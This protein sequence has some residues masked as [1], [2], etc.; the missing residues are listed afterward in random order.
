V[1]CGAHLEIAAHGELLLLNVERPF[2]LPPV[3]PTEEVAKTIVSLV[4]RPQREV[5]VANAARVFNAMHTLVPAPFEAMMARQVEKTDFQQG[6]APAP[7]SCRGMLLLEDS[8]KENWRYLAVPLP[9]SLPH[10]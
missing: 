1:R 6:H 2:S 9:I 10:I 7:Y 8:C 4:Q 3:Y 5:F